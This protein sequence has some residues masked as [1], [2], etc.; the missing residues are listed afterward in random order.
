MKAISPILLGLSLA[1]A[2]GTLAAAQDMM[3]GPP[4]V[5]QIDREFLKPG[6]AGMIHDKSE[7]HFVQAMERAKWPTNYIALNS[8]SGKSR[9]LYL[10]GYPSFDAWDKDRKAMD[11][12]PGLAAEIDQDEVNDGALLD[13]FD[14]AVFYYDEDMSY[15][16]D[17]D[18]A[19]DR[20]ME[21]SV[22]HMKPGHQKDW[23]D[24]AKLVI[25]ATK[26]A[27]TSA[28]WAM[29]EL[30]YGGS[31]EYVIFSGDKS[32]SD[33]DTSYAEGKKFNDAI[34]E[35]GM[36]KLN[37]LVQASV[38]G[39]DSE[40]FEINPRQSYAPEDWIKADPE[41]W[42]PKPAMATHAKSAAPAKK[43]GQ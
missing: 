40:L 5:L 9:A 11:M 24:A 23:E 43:S 7:S 37:D 6:K 19:H 27:G 39:S 42:M 29:Y 2:G 36:K 16:P 33:I 15:R 25:A 41:F 13:G 20:Y 26:K 21:I 14:Q 18:L 8:L 4:K 38:D 17:S 30:A 35:E 22:Y 28:H 10:T 34:G 1:V 31:E 32:L 3:S 12:N